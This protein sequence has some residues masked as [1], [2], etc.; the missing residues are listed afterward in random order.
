MYKIV[1]GYSTGNSFGSEDAVGEVGYYWDKLDDAKDALRRIVEHNDLLEEGNTWSEEQG[2][3]AS[4][5]DWY[6]ADYWAG[7]LVVKSNEGGDQVIGAF[8]QGY[9]EELKSLKIESVDDGLSWERSW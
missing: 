7:S 6:Y 2:V 4:K 1:V 9:F 3:K 5:Y 8:W